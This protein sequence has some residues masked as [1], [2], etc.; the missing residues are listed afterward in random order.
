MI[1]ARLLPLFLV[2]GAAVG[3]ETALTRYFAVAK[4]S[5]YGYWVIS[6]VMVGF[7][8][9]GVAMALARETALRHAKFLLSWLPVALVVTAASGFWGVTAN[10]F[11]PLQLQNAATYGPQI[12]NI[13]LYYAVLLPFFFLTGIYISLCFVL[14]DDRVARVYGADLL[15]A[16]AGA[17]LVLG[18]M[19]IVHPFLLVPVLLIPLALATWFGPARIAGIAGLAALAI[20]ELG[21]LTG[22]QAAYNDFKAIYAPLHVPNSRVLAQVKSPRGLYVLLDDFTERVDTDVSNDLGLLNVPGPPQT[23]GLYRDGNR[24]ASLPKPGLLDVGYAPATLAALPYVMHPHPRV[25][26]AGSSGGFRAAEALALGAREVTALEPDP[27]VLGSLRYGLGGSLPLAADPRVRLSPES[28]LAAARAG[29]G[30]DLVDVSADFL[31]AGEAN[32]TAFTAEAFTADL[33]ALAEGGIVSIPVSIRE[34]PVY[35][36]RVLSTARQALLA[37]G[38]ADP[39]KH[40]VIYRSAW[41]VRILLSLEPWSDARIATMRKWADQRS[42]D[43]SYY[44]GMDV[45]AA[46]E[47]I[48]NDLP[49]VSFDDGAVTS[50]AGSEDAIADEA[51]QVLRGEPTVSEAAFSLA[52][53]TLDRPAYYDVLRLSH[54]GTILRRLEILPQAEIGQLVNLAVLAQAVV[55]A[56]LVLL[57]PLL[58]GKKLRATGGAIVRPVVYFAALGLGFLFIEIAMIERASLFLNDRTSAFALVLTAMLVF[59]G[60]GS[61]L[62]ERVGQGGIA[63]AS[64]IAVIWCIA[65]YAGLLPAM[66]ATLDWPWLVRAGLVVLTVAPVSIALGMPFPL[67]LA[68]TGSGPMLPFAWAVNGAFSVVAT[69]LANLLATQGGL[70]WVLLAAALL[71]VICFAAYPSFRKIPQWQPSPT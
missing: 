39:A 63:I 3:F 11:N 38:V 27:I 15:G 1:R 46:R 44:P 47:A 53:A 40:V 14:N 25:L 65:A 20:C 4:W 5:E 29:T 60:F 31:D 33:L 18:L 48:Y 8:F 41:N 71:Y 68:K 54:L 36:L 67:G 45:A 49:A 35:A 6:I 16:G 55:I 24:I 56:L 69:P 7:A 2:S 28:P 9:S 42:F 50:G 19:F 61:L 37:A 52:P 59:S 13:A 58:A 22:S 43:V 12:W 57:V 66:L 62:A 30:Y 64:G 10:P 34:F 21:L 23:Y 32:S 70:S 17:A 51:G 26:L